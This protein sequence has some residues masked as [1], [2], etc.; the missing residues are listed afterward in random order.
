MLLSSYVIKTLLKLIHTFNKLWRQQGL[1]KP[2][3][4]KPIASLEARGNNVL[5]EA[6][7][8]LIKSAIFSQFAFRIQIT[9][10]IL[11]KRAS[12]VKLIVNSVEPL[13]Y[14]NIDHQ[15]YSSVEPSL[16]LFGLSTVHVLLLP[17]SISEV[18]NPS[19]IKRDDSI[20]EA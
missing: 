11:S 8:I 16:Y 15:W 2:L 9:Q 3:L 14:I 12:W 19:P 1:Y 5:V 10:F 13:P 20:T 17:G 18:R 4:L 7:L 6:L